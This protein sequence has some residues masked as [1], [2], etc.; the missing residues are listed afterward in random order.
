MFPDAKDQIVAFGVKNLARTLT[1]EGVLDL[2]VSTIIPRLAL[3]WKKDDDSSKSSQ[4]E[5]HEAAE[6]ASETAN[7][8]RT[9]V[10]PENQERINKSF[11]KAHRLKSMSFS[12]AWRWM[13]LLEFKYDARR[14]SL[15]VDGREREDVVAN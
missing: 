15:Y 10:S 5:Q 11:L 13:R 8:H 3:Q 6:A 12:T 1:I 14:K 2:I 9:G 7:E 4:E